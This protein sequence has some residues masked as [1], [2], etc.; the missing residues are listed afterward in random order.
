MAGSFVM[1]ARGKQ[2]H[3]D[4]RCC[5][6]RSSKAFL[7]SL[8]PMS[9]S[10]TE[11]RLRMRAFDP[12]SAPLLRPCL[13]CIGFACCASCCVLR[14]VRWAPRAGIPSRKRSHVY[15]VPPQAAAPHRSHHTVHTPLYTPS[16]DFQ[17]VQPIYHT[18]HTPS[19]DFQSVQPHDQLL[20]RL[21]CTK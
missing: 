19:L 10:I 18:M 20:S 15:R 1:D 13:A 21:W 6:S 8:T 3:C 14:C 17:S 16:L 4:C 2:D 7:S 9:L 5:L 11:E 12:R